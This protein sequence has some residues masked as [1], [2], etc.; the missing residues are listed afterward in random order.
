MSVEES[1]MSEEETSGNS[2]NDE[3]L[4]SSSVAKML[5]AEV[6]DAE[7][8][9]E[10]MEGQ[11]IAE[12]ADRRT[13]ERDGTSQTHPDYDTLLARV[14]ESASNTRHK[15]R[16]TVE[17]DDIDDEATDEE[18]EGGDGEDSEEDI[19]DWDPDDDIY[20]PELSARE[21]L[22][23]AFMRDVV[24]LGTCA[25][26]NLDPDISQL[27]SLYCCPRQTHVYLMKTN[28]CCGYMPIN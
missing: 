23:G 4:A 17:D 13:H 22:F 24:A 5:G 16:V 8:A 10:T 19:D 28:S 11:E 3:D 26:L 18:E 25:R 9:G 7:G 1:E 2:D 20:N 21:R 6:L 14:S 12:E 15:H 27:C